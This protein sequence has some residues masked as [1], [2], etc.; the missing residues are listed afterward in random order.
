[1][2][3]AIAV[4]IIVV[5]LVIITS[6]VGQRGK[7]QKGSKS[8]SRAAIIKSA[9]KKL[10][11][12]PNN[13]PALTELSEFYYQEHDWERALPLF[14]NLLKLAVTNKNIDYFHVALRQGETALKLKR[15]IDALRGLMSAAKINSDNFEVNYYIGQAHFLSGAADKAVPC[16]RRALTFN[17][18]M[19]GM[20]ELMG[21][22]LYNIKNY[23]DSLPFLRRALEET[24]ED[25]TLL[26]STADAMQ[27]TGFGD[28]ALKVFMHLR[29]DPEYGARSCLAAG[30]MHMNGGT[31][32][33]AM[34]DF[35]IALKHENITPDTLL[36]VK[37]RLAGCYI[38]NND[39]DQGLNL[40]KEIQMTNSSYRDV[41]AMVTR[42]TELKQNKNLQ[43]YLTAGSGDFVALCRKLVEKFYGRAKIR[44]LDISVTSDSTEVLTDIET[45]KWEDS[46]I[47]RFYR[48][49]GAIGELHIRDFHGR[50]RDA[51]AGRGVCVTAGT[52]SDEA[53]KF[54]E[55]RP[56]DLVDKSELIHRLKRVNVI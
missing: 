8:R 36:E 31:F 28:K 29:A 10:S 4:L 46:V 16:L 43:I 42:Y 47:F 55:G 45:A 15:P 7:V 33:K 56:I 32:D 2:A 18:E 48:T 11:Q 49:T 53:K 30:I 14:E 41:N 34:Q 23:K 24:P 44:I 3:I 40:L 51:R 22:A 1:M 19:P 26:F 50:I 37:Y 39:V 20:N 35:E 54:I 13:V 27:Q 25:K 38:Q 6:I 5:F 9:T 21:L 52:Y 12:N 17:R